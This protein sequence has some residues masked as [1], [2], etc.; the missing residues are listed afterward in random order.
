[1]TKEQLK[2]RIL[3]A[4]GRRKADLVIKNCR[5]IDVFSQRILEGDIA[6]SDEWI[7]GIG[8]YEGE[9][10]IDAGGRYASPGL[11]DGHIHVESSYLCPE[12]LGRLLVPHGTSTIVAD[13]HEIVNVG[14]VPALDYMLRAAARTKLDIIYLLPSCVPATPFEHAGLV[15]DADAMDEPIH[16]DEIPG[17]AEFMNYPGVIN[18]DDPVL[19]KIM[20]AQETGKYIDGHSPGL[21][22]KDLE[23]YASIRIRSDHECGT[24]EEMQE[25]ISLGMYIPLRQGS[26]CR[27]LRD[28]L[29]GVTP[30]NSRRC[31]L[32][33]DDLQAKTI[34]SSGHIDNDLR[35]CVEEGLD[36]LTAIRMATLNAA[37]CFRLEDRGAIAPGYLANITLLDDLKDF[38]A[39]RV[40]QHGEL[41]AEDGTY[42]PEVTREDITPVR[43]SVHLKDFSEEKLKMHL[44][45]GHV[46]VIAIQPGGVVTKKETADV[47]VENGEFVRTPEQDIVKAAVVE[48]HQMTGNV[49][50]GFLKGYGIQK[51]AVA[52]SIAHDSHNIIVT[53]VSDREMAFAV[54]KLKEQGGGIVLVE[55]GRVLGSMPMPI[56]GLMSDR[57]GEEV[58]AKLAELH[59]TAWNELGVSR[60]VE[61]V[62]TLTFMSLAVIP[63]LKL[64][65]EGLFDVTAFDFLPVEAENE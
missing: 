35:I 7:A 41:V 2:K 20:L 65:D 9:R 47:K 44:T 16:R 26:A 64:T 59:E 32:C 34:L 10:E 1:M 51:G 25:K 24:V 38:R 19:D 3:I 8:S 63:E 52:V 40:I 5:I 58:A 48:R 22:G 11:I 60:D 53:G 37:E 55:G 56:A 46:H 15:F 43:N 45:S 30:E 12:E 50:C 21:T 14:G 28:L 54:E 39:D 62:M 36:P 4:G 57:S 18:A 42:L 29:K 27:N 6:I 13:P 17:L 31:I 23:A 61:P 33:S 49:A